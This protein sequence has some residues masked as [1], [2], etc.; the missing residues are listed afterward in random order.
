MQIT[1]VTT[2]NEQNGILV[3]LYLMDDDPKRYAILQAALAKLESALNAVVPSVRLGSPWSTPES[4]MARGA[5]A[6][7]LLDHSAIWLLD[8]HLPADKC[9]SVL[10]ELQDGFPQDCALTLRELR[11]GTDHNKHLELACTV[12]SLA[13]FRQRKGI[14][15]S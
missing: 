11:Q 5:T 7:A 14:F 1:T 10:E 9:K 15:V 13:L 12:L 4:W 6:R 8:W 2:Q 3:N